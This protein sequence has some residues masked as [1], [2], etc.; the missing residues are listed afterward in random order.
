VQLSLGAAGIKSPRDSDLQQ[1]SLG[2][3]LDLA[4]K[5]RRG[6]LLFWNGHVAIARDGGTIVHANAHHMA[7]VIEDTAEAIARIKAAGSE[8]VAIKRI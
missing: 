8:L 5:L 2:Q 3:P 6:D 1:A 7:T 4:E